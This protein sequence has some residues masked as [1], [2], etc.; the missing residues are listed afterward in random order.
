MIE[1]EEVFVHLKNMKVA[2]SVDKK[3]T[4]KGKFSSL[5][6]SWIT[7]QTTITVSESVNVKKTP[8]IFEIVCNCSFT[9]IK[10]RIYPFFS[11]FLSSYF[12]PNLLIHL[13][14]F[15]FNFFLYVDVE[16]QHQSDKDGSVQKRS[17]QISVN[18]QQK[19][20]RSC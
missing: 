2:P 12:W 14:K 4:P 16:D 20:T 17:H 1:T 9:S 8:N 7:L 18:I 19:S 13:R 5:S 10:N 6:Y 3:L 15:Q 11:S